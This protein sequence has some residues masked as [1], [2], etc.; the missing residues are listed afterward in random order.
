MEEYI[1]ARL[2]SG[3]SQYIVYIDIINLPCTTPVVFETVYDIIKKYAKRPFII[4]QTLEFIHVMYINYPHTGQAEL[5]R[6]INY[7]M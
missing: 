7:I 6:D 5:L 3:S 4:C 2:E 1:K